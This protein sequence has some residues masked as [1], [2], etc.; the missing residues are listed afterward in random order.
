MLVIQSHTQLDMLGNVA[1]FGNSNVFKAK[2]GV[3]YTLRRMASSG[4]A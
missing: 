2:E 1:E 3:A 4:G